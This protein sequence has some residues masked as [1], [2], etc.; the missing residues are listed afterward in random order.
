MSNSKFDLFIFG[1]TSELV[2]ALIQDYKP[3]FLEHV[4]RLIITQRGETYPALY[5]EFNPVSIQLDCANPQE[6]GKNLKAM[7]ETYASSERPMHILPTYGVFNWNYAPKNPVFAYREDGYQVN[8]NARLQIIDAF[9][10]YPNARFHLFGSLFA[11]FPYTGDYAL[12]MW[13]INQLPKNSEYKDLDLIIYNLGGM[14]TRFWKWEAGP[15]NNPFVYDRLPTDKIVET[16]F[17]NP[18]NRGIFTFY[19]TVAARIACF[20]G[21]KGVR[22]L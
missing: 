19:P 22:V 7:V 9:R 12:S 4:E 2:Q 11:N 10:G 21:R 5:Q 15:K 6:F 20:L 18:S 17:K 8:L 3:W 16:G 1:S 13:Y 14:K